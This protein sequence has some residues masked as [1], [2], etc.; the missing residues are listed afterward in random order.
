MRAPL[1]GYQDVMKRDLVGRLVV[2]DIVRALDI[3]RN[4]SDPWYRCQSLAHVAWHLQ[5]QRQLKKVIKEALQAAYEQKEPN[6]IVSVAAWPVRVMV[7]KRDPLLSSV[8]DELLEKIE[9]EPKCGNGPASDQWG[10]SRVR[11]IRNV[12]CGL[13]R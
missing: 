5:D 10:R 8:V 3:A 2:S 7:Q 1:R 9:T 13:V 12:R 6:P 11:G 4:I